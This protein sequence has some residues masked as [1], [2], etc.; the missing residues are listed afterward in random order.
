MR[1]LD[2]RSRCSLISAIPMCIALAATESAKAEQQPRGLRELAGQFQ[3][4]SSL[5]FSS[6][7]QIEMQAVAYNCPIVVGTPVFGQI[8][9]WATGNRYL[10]NSSADPIAYPGMQTQVAYDGGRFQLLR[11]D[12]TLSRSKQ[13][14]TTLLPI[15]PNPLFELLQFRFALTDDTYGRE[16][17]LKDIQDDCPSDEYFEV[18]WKI[19]EEAG[20]QFERA[21]FPG[22]KLEGKYY[23]HEVYVEPGIRDRPVRID[24]VS[25]GTKLTSALFE[26]YCR[27]DTC[28]GVAYWP[29]HV[30]LRAFA[31]D[32]TDAVRM[33][34]CIFD[35]EVEADIPLDVFTITEDSAERIWDD[36]RR[37]FIPKS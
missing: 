19:V 4:V 3:D 24:R 21:I 27:I 10:V 37:E 8:E 34:F 25:D 7:V 9:Y 14:H 22:G 36:D 1:T 32:G 31:T 12:G 18:E 28:S 17:R 13:E 2:M 20:N 11:S 29:Q 6:S 33:S 30:E 23:V 35:M 15:L 16:L 26:D 5:H